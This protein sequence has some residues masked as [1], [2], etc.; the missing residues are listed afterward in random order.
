MGHFQPHYSFLT[1]T[2]GNSLANYH[3]SKVAERLACS[4]RKHTPAERRTMMKNR[5]NTLRSWALG[6]L[7]SI[8][9]IAFVLLLVVA[10]ATGN[11]TAGASEGTVSGQI[12]GPLVRLVLKALFLNK[13]MGALNVGT[14]C[15]RQVISA[16][17]SGPMDNIA[18]LPVGESLAEWVR[19]ESARKEER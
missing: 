7:E 14:R 12:A 6:R 4:H 13:E 17:R 16:A 15:L 5:R 3:A 8:V 2:F 18:D 9:K 11:T 1:E 10:L 19:F